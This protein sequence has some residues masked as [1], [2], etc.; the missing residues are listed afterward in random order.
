MKHTIDSPYAVRTAILA[1]LHEQ[2]RTRYAFAKECHAA[3]LC[4]VQT[5]DAILTHPESL[6]STTPTLPTAISL[7][8]AVGYDLVA[9]PKGASK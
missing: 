7:L 9:V 3:A 5:V 4:K 1:A 8:N 2:G 6:T